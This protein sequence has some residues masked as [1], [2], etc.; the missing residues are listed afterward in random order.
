MC[1]ELIAARLDR[2]VA[3]ELVQVAMA[4]AECLDGR[5]S[6]ILTR[7]RLSFDSSASRSPDCAADYVHLRSESVLTRR[8][9][10]GKSRLTRIPSRFAAD[11]YDDF[12]RV[13]KSDIS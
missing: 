5:R 9:D 1:F 11:N 3:H 2:S 7:E 10:L 13:I 12:T 8:Q 6:M 4:F